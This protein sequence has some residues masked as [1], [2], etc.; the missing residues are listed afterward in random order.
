MKVGNYIHILVS[1]GPCQFL[2]DVDHV[3]IMVN[4]HKI[5]QSDRIVLPV[6][7][8]LDVLPGGLWDFDQDVVDVALPA[9]HQPEPVIVVDDHVVG[10]ADPHRVHFVL[11]QHVPAELLHARV[12]E[13]NGRN[14]LYELVE[15]EIEFGLEPRVEHLVGVAVLLH[16]VDQ[17]L[18]LLLVAAQGLHL[19]HVDVQV[20][21][22]LIEEVVLRG[23][24]VGL[25][26]EGPKAAFNEEHATRFAMLRYLQRYDLQFWILTIVR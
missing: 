18:E 13:R 11:A 22:E 4:V 25:E 20:L 16:Q 5:A 14:V 21:C 15:G 6:P 19:G 3:A 12:C 17:V 9:P 1:I 7:A 10:Q 26:H 8:S 2:A 23:L 24:I